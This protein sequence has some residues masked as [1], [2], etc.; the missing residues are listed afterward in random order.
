VKRR[1]YVYRRNSRFTEVRGAAGLHRISMGGV[2]A[3]F[4][5]YRHPCTLDIAIRI[6][7]EFPGT[8][9]A[10]LDLARTSFFTR[11]VCARCNLQLF[12]TTSHDDEA[13]EENQIE[14][15]YLRKSSSVLTSAMVDVSV[16]PV[17]SSSTRTLCHSAC[18]CNERG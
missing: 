2:N 1:G 7:P 11:I 14:S 5:L 8:S 4:S 17:P 6:E 16:H 13:H 3:D 15:R 10:C 12:P 9:G 18:K